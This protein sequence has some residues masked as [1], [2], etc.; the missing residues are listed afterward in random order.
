[1][2]GYLF[3]DRDGQTPL[4]PDLKKGLKIKHITTI[5]ELDEYE[6]DNIIKG[7]V[8]LE[9]Q[10]AD[11]INY[12]FWVKLHKKLFSNVWSWAGEV[13]KHELQN[14]DF[15]MPQNIWPEIKKLEDDL[16]FWI[17]NKSFDLKEVAARFHE[18]FET[19]HPFNNG[20]GRIG[21]IVVQYFCKQ[22]GISIPTW[23]VYLADNP[24]RRRSQYIDALTSARKNK[25]YSKLLKIMYS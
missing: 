9:K 24:N 4:P 22:S 21:R 5:G 1:M 17:E 3:K 2:S 16:I 6:E 18:R 7:L 15:V 13:R 14:L 25:S 10:T 12:T 20:N 8:W 19:I 11:S 23:G